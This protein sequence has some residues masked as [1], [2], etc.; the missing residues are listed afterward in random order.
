MGKR[1]LIVLIGVIVALIL[2]GIFLPSIEQIVKKI[3]V[4]ID[5]A[6]EETPAIES[7]G[8][9]RNARIIYSKY[10]DEISYYK[11]GR[12]YYGPFYPYLRN[13]LDWIKNNTPQ[14][15]IF[16][17]LPWHQGMIS[18][19]AERETIISE[20]LVYLI[21]DILREL[22]VNGTGL[23]KIPPKVKDVIEALL[24]ED[25]NKT[26][27]IMKKYGASYVFMFAPKNATYEFCMEMRRVLRL[28][29]LSEKEYGAD[30][31]GG[32]NTSVE[33]YWFITKASNFMLARLIKNRNLP[34]VFV[35]VYQ[36]DYAKIYLL[37]QAP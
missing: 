16:L 19:Y 32:I 30:F 37:K 3:P 36:D 12:S 24:T 18:G 6:I 10:G 1:S 21:E 4:A 11:N 15:A 34:E 14:D 17:A 2:G 9:K 25:A 20:D 27:E 31:G 28:S 22:A 23:E 7:I 35:L 26:I 33:K 8:G 13:A 29:G 5:V